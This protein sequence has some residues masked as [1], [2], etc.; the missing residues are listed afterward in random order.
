MQRNYQQVYH[1]A[2][3]PQHLLQGVETVVDK[4]EQNPR[5]QIDFHQLQ[6]PVSSQGGIS[7]TLDPSEPNWSGR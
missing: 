4:L 2:Q 3:E 6:V 1:E 5:E 7:R